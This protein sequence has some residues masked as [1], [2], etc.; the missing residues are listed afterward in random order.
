MSFPEFA[1]VILRHG[2]HFF[3]IQR[4]GDSRHWPHYWGFPGGKKEESEDIFITAKRELLEEVGVNIE[5]TN[6]VT[7]IVIH[8]QYIDGERK[9]TLFLFENWEWVP[10]NCEPKIHSN[11]GWF[12]LEE[13][14]KPMI[15][16]LHWWLRALLAWED[17]FEYDGIST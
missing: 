10:E 15:S 5:K 6:I 2:S 14:P 4:S 3:L 8:A 7:E 9:N 13:L 1:W 12:T 16:H 17:S 11:I